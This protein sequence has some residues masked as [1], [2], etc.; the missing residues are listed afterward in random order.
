MNSI[1]YND[2]LLTKLFYIPL[3]ILK[4]RKVITDNMSLF[5]KNLKERNKF[6]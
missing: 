5:K 3:K 1:T 2:Y 4:F 6:K